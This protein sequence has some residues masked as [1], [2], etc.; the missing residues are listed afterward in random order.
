MI[1]FEVA[2]FF[3]VV[4][5]VIFVWRGCVSFCEEMLRDFFVETW[6]DYF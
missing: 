4:S 3:C 6:R 2:G 1:F 5:C